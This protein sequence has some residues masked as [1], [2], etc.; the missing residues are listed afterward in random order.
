MAR[1][2][3]TENMLLAASGGTAPDPMPVSNQ[4]VSMSEGPTAHVQRLRPGVMQRT[5]SADAATGPDPPMPLPSWTSESS[6][7]MMAW[8]PDPLGP[9]DSSYS[10]NYGPDPFYTDGSGADEFQLQTPLNLDSQEF[11]SEDG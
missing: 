11:R 1:I 4:G 8:E 3:E 5:V 6:G 10:S 7:P 9:S 2:E